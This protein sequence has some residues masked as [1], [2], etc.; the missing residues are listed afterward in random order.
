MIHLPAILSFCAAGAL[1]VLGL[2]HVGRGGKSAQKV[3]FILSCFTLAAAEA[4]LG[5]MLSSVTPPGALLAFRFF[6]CFSMFVPPVLIPFFLLLG[7]Q[8]EKE[9]L[10]RPGCWVVGFVVV[11]WAIIGVIAINTAPRLIVSEIHFT[12]DAFWGLTFSGYGKL[13]SMYLLLAN[14][15]GLFLLEN[16]YRSSSIVGKVTLKYPLL[17]I[18]TVTVLTFVVISRILA[19]SITD[20]NF[21]AIH[22]C[23]FIALSASFF[24]ATLRYDL[25]E[26]HAF[27]GR[28]VAKS[29]LTI[30]ISGLYILALALISFL[31][32]LLGLSYDLFTFTVLGLFAVFLLVAVL[33]SGRAKRRLRHFIETN[34]YASRYDYRKEWKRYARLMSSSET[35]DEFLSNFINLICNTMLVERGIVWADV[36]GGKLASY[37]FGRAEPDLALLRKSSELAQHGSVVFI[38]ERPVRTDVISNGEYDEAGTSGSRWIRA[39]AAIG[40]EEER[41]GSI[42]LGEK[43]MNAKYTEED[44][45][46]LTTLADQAAL[47]LDNLLIKEQILDSK[48]MESFNR[49]SSFVIH[50]LKNAIGMLSLTA[51]NARE[52]LD[53]P[54]F[55]KDAFNTIERSVDKMK[56]LIH[57][58]NALKAPREISKKP[59]DISEL[60]GRAIE[61]VKPIAGSRGIQLELISDSPVMGEVDASALERIVENLLMNALDAT[62]EGGRVRVR[63]AATGEEW[64]EIAVEDTGSGFEPEYLSE[65]LFRPFRSTKKG[66]LGIGLVMCKTL[67]T[68]HGG[69]IVIESEPGRGATVFIRIPASLRVDG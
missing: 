30:T 27:I 31:A 37:G 17:G 52:N 18:L 66:G 9:V 32:R 46:C 35:I 53:D 16:A 11:L 21:L 25:F 44:R 4:S 36:K 45:E 68:A 47:T 56:G 49:I 43:S 20:R 54:E 69:D 57:S 24:F 23:G 1:L 48:Q 38:D 40:N 64:V 7:R 19:V 41:L 13:A 59:E 60:V 65:H 28:D 55:Q 62:S 67:V 39:V 50:D 29:V 51:E 3:F 14:I 34:F 15:F 58:L 5:S 61:S 26:I 63:A 10:S 42:I 33:I 2:F 22:S 8:N 12:E 6:F